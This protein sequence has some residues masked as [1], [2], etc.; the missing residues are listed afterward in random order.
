V[1]HFNLNETPEYLVQ[2][3]RRHFKYLFEHDKDLNLIDGVLDRIKDYYE[4]KLQLVVAS[5]ASMPNINRVF[6]RFDLNQY[7]SGKFSG[8]DLKQSKPHPEIFIK[9]SD[10]TGYAKNECM[11]IEDSTNGI[12]ASKSAGIFCVAYKSTHSNGQDYSN[13]NLVISDFKEISYNK[14]QQAFES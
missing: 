4:N 1:T 9:A 12:N 10:F 14:I 8:A 7:F 6:K 13:A 11:V 2:L 3:K 5:S